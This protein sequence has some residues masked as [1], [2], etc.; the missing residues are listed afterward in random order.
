MKKSFTYAVTRCK[1]LCILSH[2]L[3]KAIRGVIPYPSLLRY[4]CAMHACVFRALV[5]VSVYMQR[6]RGS[7]HQVHT[8]FL[9]TTYGS[10]ATGFDARFES[11][12]P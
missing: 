7:I 1:A 10:R 9:V 3:S 2:T 8:L 5:V 11:L 6:I 12:Q 4:V